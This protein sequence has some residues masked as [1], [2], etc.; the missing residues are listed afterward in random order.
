MDEEF[1]S[2]GRKVKESNKLEEMKVVDAK[3]QVK[4]VKASKNEAFKR[5]ET[6]QKEIGDIKTATK[7]ALRK[8]EMLE[9][10]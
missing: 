6:T 4:G 3:A 10:A 1:K 9:A 7:E 5:L 2:L 8:A